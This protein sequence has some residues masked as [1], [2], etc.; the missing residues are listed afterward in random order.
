MEVAFF[1]AAIGALGL[2]AIVLVEGG[3]ARAAL[4]ELSVPSG[5]AGVLVSSTPM[6]VALFAPRF[7]RSAEINRVQ[8]VGL[9]VGLVGVALV[10]GV[11]AVSSLGQF[12]GALAIL[13]A[14]GRGALSSFIVKLQSTGTRTCRRARRAS[15]V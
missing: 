2:L 9:V 14:A 13:G 1:Q 11:Q 7:N 12:L 5:L 8:T 6:F 15:S 3:R 10:V 4:G